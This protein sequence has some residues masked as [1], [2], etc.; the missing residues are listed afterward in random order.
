M[1]VLQVRLKQAEYDALSAYAAATGQTMSEVIHHFLHLL[2]MPGAEIVIEAT[3][4][5]VKPNPRPAAQLVD[6]PATSYV[7][8]RPVPKPSKA[9]R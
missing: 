9:K 3:P 7:T 4:V 1:P 8:F 2:A 5:V 6:K